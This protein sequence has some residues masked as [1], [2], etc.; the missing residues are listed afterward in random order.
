MASQLY[1]DSVSTLGRCFRWPGLLC[2]ALLAPAPAVL[3][4]SGTPA[5]PS[6]VWTTW[7]WNPWVIGSLIL[8]AGLYW[9]GGRAWWQTAVRERARRRRESVAFWSGWGALGVALVSP[10][11][12][13]GGVLFSAHMVQHEVLMLVAA[14]LLVLGRPLPLCLRALPLPWRRER[15]LRKCPAV[16]FELPGFKRDHAPA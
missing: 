5:T 6:L 8:A 3:A 1:P 4:H 16:P 10:L 14:P 9:R 2:L 15:L 11:H 12:A 13:L 7:S